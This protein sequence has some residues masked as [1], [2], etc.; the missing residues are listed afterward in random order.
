M[1]VAAAGTIA[2]RVSPSAVCVQRATWYC[3]LVHVPTLRCGDD[4]DAASVFVC[5]SGAW[6]LHAQKRHAVAI[7]L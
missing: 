2:A 6:W 1:L 5:A 4:D 3:G 7:F